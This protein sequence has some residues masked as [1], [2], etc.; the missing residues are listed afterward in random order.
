M[1]RINLLPWR[2]ELREL[3]RKQFLQALLLVVLGAAAAV[4]LT[5]VM[6]ERGNDRQQARNDLLRGEIRVLDDQLGEIRD[7][8]HARRDLLARMQVIQEL[9]GNRPVSVRIF[10][11]L[12]QTLAEGVFLTSLQLSGEQLAVEGIAESNDRISELMRN[13]E[14]SEWFGTPGLRGLREAPEYGSQAARFDLTVRRVLP[15]AH[16]ED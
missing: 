12:V 11:E 2:E 14:R 7:L 10:D 13:L 5:G 3:R 8:Q 15:R 1:P 4:L 9:Q 16:E 6:L